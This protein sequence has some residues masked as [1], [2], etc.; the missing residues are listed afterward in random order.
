MISELPNLPV[1]HFILCLLHMFVFFLE[2]QSSCE[3]FYVQAASISL[4]HDKCSVRT[5]HKIGPCIN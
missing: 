5:C 1:T 2:S 3:V 4:S